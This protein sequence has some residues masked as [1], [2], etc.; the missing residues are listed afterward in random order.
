MHIGRAAKRVGLTVDAIR[1]YERNALL[2]RAPRTAG[3]FREYRET[4]LETLE[5][6][7]RLQGL[8]FKLREV[9]GLLELRASKIQPCAPVRR[10]LQQK[11]MDV[12]QK[13]SALQKLQRDLRLALRACDRALRKADAH[14]PILKENDSP[15]AERDR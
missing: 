1:F 12:R 15:A 8:G 6:I 7:R 10:R 9:R 13:I 11:L 3:G 14:C 2:P 5:F 4:D